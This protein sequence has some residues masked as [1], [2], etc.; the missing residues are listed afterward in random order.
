MTARNNLR[1]PRV[2]VPAMRV[3]QRDRRRGVG[4]VRG[5]CEATPK[6]FCNHIRDDYKIPDLLLPTLN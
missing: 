1:A 4:G 3:R 2:F 6:H 5:G